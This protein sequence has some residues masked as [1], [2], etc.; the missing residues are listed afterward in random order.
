MDYLKRFKNTGVILS[1]IALIG[2]LLLTLGFEFDNEKLQNSAII[3][4]NI[5]IVL[6]ICNNPETDG[7]DIP[8]KSKK[9]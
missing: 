3:I 9:I 6:G 2:S 7:L 4:C 5:L 8:I 1:L